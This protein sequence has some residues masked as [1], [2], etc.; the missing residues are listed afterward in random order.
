MSRKR[1]SDEVDPP[2]I[3]DVNLCGDAMDIYKSVM[4]TCAIKTDIVQALIQ[5]KENWDDVFYIGSYMTFPNDSRSS[6]LKDY[7]VDEYTGERTVDAET[8]K[9]TVA[10]IKKDITKHK[11]N[12]NILCFTVSA[13]NSTSNI[14]HHVGFVY[15]PKERKLKMYDPGLRSWGPELGKII[16][17]VV[18]SALPEDVTLVN[19]YYSRQFCF[20]CIGTQDA[21]RGGALYELSV[22][23]REK[24]GYGWS[25]SHRES[26]CQTWSLILMLNDIQIVKD[27]D[28]TSVLSEQKLQDWHELSVPDLEVFTYPN[29]FESEWASK[30]EGD[31]DE[32]ELY[33]ITKKRYKTYRNFLLACMKNFNERIKIPHSGDS[34]MC[35][36]ITLQV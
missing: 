21:C 35:D 31:N 18:K 33:R 3:E 2:K 27:S 9:H 25:G 26:F 34:A 12:H 15:A 4:N 32:Q 22:I 5:G 20:T 17:Q 14:S 13:I 10:S 19:S 8:F 7:Y 36:N 24:L 28:N 11:K 6:E 23:A 29:D 30:E 16:A 1:K